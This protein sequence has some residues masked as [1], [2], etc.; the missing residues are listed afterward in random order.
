MAVGI[1]IAKYK[2]FIF[3]LSAVFAAI[4]GVLYTHY[5]TFIA[6]STFGFMFSIELVAMV[7]LGGM[8]SVWGAVIGAFFLTILPELLRVFEN[9]EIVLF[10]GIMVVCMIF[11]PRGIAGA[12]SGGFRLLTKGKKETNHG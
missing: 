9:I 1:D 6:P 5:L 8:G 3:T 2:L 12:I 7:V 10:G 4:A 11:M